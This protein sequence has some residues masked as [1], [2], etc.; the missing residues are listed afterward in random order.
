M[1]ELEVGDDVYA[2]DGTTTR[3]TQIRVSDPAHAYEF[4]LSDGQAFRAAGNQ[5]WTVMTAQTRKSWDSTKVRIRA[6]RVEEFT[7]KAESLFRLAETTAEDQVA[8]LSSIASLAGYHELSLYQMRLPIEA[9]RT[10]ADVQTTRKISRHDMSPIAKY[11]TAKRRSFRGVPVGAELAAAIEGQWMTARELAKTLLQRDPR[12]DDCIKAHKL[13]RLHCANSMPTQGTKPLPVYPV[14]A[15]LLLLAE[16]LMVSA[17]TS[18]SGVAAMAIETAV[19]SR[20]IASTPIKPLESDPRTNFSFRVSSAIDGPIS[21]LPLDPYVLGVWLGD[22]S[23]WKSNGITSA[24]AEIPLWVQEAGYELYRSE[25]KGPNNK[26]KTYY[27][28]KLHSD[29]VKA[30]LSTSPYASQTKAVKRI[31]PEYLRASA[32]QRAA[33]LSGLMDTDGTIGTS[34]CSEICLTNRDLAYDTLELIRSL[35]IICNIKEGPAGYTLPDGTHKATGTRY[36]MVF[37]TNQTVFRLARKRIRLPKTLRPTQNQ[38]FIR[39]AQLVPAETMYEVFTTDPN[40]MMLI[41][42]FVPVHAANTLHGVSMSAPRNSP[43]GDRSQCDAKPQR[44]AQ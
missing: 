35:S 7:A 30:G 19:S 33:V 23:A 20:Q 8:S 29:L 43:D 15:V 10:T 38:Y 32:H 24:D 41:G 17:R 21:E 18:D 28:K 25:G 16:R 36:R 3:I 14:R 34:G 13:I 22:G 37:T 11:F 26:A 9:L 12:K 39:S 4:E 5:P 27:F 1:S 44:A 6:A 40:K 2:H 42:A 31:P